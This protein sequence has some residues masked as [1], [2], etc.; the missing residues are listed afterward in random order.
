MR[1]ASEQDLGVGRWNVYAM[2]QVEHPWYSPLLAHIKESV[3]IGYKNMLA[4][5]TSD[6]CPILAEY[7]WLHAV[8]KKEGTPA[9]PKRKHIKGTKPYLSNQVAYDPSLIKVGTKVLCRDKKIRV[10]L[11]V[12]NSVV[13]FDNNLTS[14]SSVYLDC[15]RDYRKGTNKPQ[16]IMKIIVDKPIRDPYQGY[17]VNVW[18]FWQGA[19]P[20]DGDVKVQVWCRGHKEEVEIGSA[21]PSEYYR[22]EWYSDNC[23]IMAFFIVGD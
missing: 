15:G 4:M 21:Y 20:V 18:H 19:P 2:Y 16:D 14:T 12:G 5:E 13:V 10:V 11:E 9:K 23:D 6:G 3:Y 1:N 22:W 7:E 17:A 8:P